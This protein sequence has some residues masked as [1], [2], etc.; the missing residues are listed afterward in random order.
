MN[1]YRIWPVGLLVLAGCAN[2]YQQHYSTQVERAPQSEAVPLIAA[3]GPPQLVTTTSMR[4]DA[5]KLLEEGYLPIGR[6]E[7]KSNNMYASSA[8]QQGERVGA[9]VVV[10]K[11]K[12]LGR[13]VQSVPMHEWIPDR[14]ITTTETRRSVDSE[15]RYRLTH[16]SEATT[17]IEGEYETRWVPQAV[18]TFEFVA[19]FWKKAHPPR[20]GVLVSEPSQ[21][22]RKRIGSNR[23]VEI[24]AVV[25]DSPAYYADLLRGDIILKLEK[26]D[27]YGTTGFFEQVQKLAGREV[28]VSFMRDGKSQTAVANLRP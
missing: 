17:V 11:H 15:G 14:R 20:F 19:T 16:L 2:P 6:S 5:I 1:L 4:D 25:R 9:A 3:Q 13:E 23:G 22:L 21:E 27:I 26:T 24:K 18:D 10:I 28:T 12:H 7:F 8:L